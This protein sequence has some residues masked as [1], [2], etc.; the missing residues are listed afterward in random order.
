MSQSGCYRAAESY[1]KHKNE[2]TINSLCILCFLLNNFRP[3]P[4][5]VVSSTTQKQQNEGL[6]R[7]RSRLDQLQGE[8][9]SERKSARD[10][11]CRLADRSEEAEGTA[12]RAT[13]V[14]EKESAE[15]RASLSAEFAQVRE[16]N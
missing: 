9:S 14:A 13:G 11:L 3:H 10:E 4:T 16:V 5:L 6:E 15:L 7:W 12:R 1:A 2:L 8:C